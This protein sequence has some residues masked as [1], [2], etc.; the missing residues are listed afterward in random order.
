MAE[1]GAP[2]SCVRSERRHREDHL[3]AVRQRV[4]ELAGDEARVRS[5]LLAA[6][7]SRPAL[8]HYPRAARGQPARCLVCGATAEA[9]GNGPRALGYEG[10]EPLLQQSCPAREREGPHIQANRLGGVA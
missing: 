10:S 5:A 9:L 8:G 1:L 2:A 3:V 6:T 7:V 4:A